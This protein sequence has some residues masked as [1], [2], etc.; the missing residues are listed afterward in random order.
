M[1]ENKPWSIVARFEMRH[2]R[3]DDISCCCCIQTRQNPTKTFSKTRLRC[4]LVIT[5]C[6]ILFKQALHS[7]N[8][9][10]PNMQLVFTI[11]ILCWFACVQSA[12]ENMQRISNLEFVLKLKTSEIDLLCALLNW[13]PMGFLGR[14][15]N[16]YP[17]LIDPFRQTKKF[18]FCCCQ[19]CP[20]VCM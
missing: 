17:L 1:W 9:C 15:I 2:C 12:V 14:T 6:F 20:H 8:D 18:H 4:G 7:F 19:L 10:T 5:I 11:F 13:Q 3:T 16:G